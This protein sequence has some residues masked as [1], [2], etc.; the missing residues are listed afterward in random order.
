MFLTVIGTFFNILLFLLIMTLVVS[1]HELGH[2]LFA[3]RAK[4]LCHE[5][6]IGF[7][8]VLF[9]R[10]RGETRFSVRSI[11]IGGYVSMAGE[12]IES[13]L[14][15]I[16]MTIRVGFDQKG[17]VNRIV[18]NPE[19][20]Q[21]HDFQ[22][23]KI[24]KYDLQGKD[25]KDLYINDYK[26]NRDAIYVFDKKQLQIAPYNR[27]YS[28][29]SKSQR[30]MTTF[31]GPLMNLILALVLYL[32]ISFIIGVPNT[33]S[34]V[35]GGVVDESPASGIIL[36]GDEIT[37]INGVSIDA[38]SSDDATVTSLGSELDKY[39]DNATFT[40]TVLRDGTEMTLDAI[41]PQYYFFGLGFVS[42][43]TQPGL[44]I[45]GPLYRNSLLLPG[46]VIQAING[47][48]FT[49]WKDVILYQLSHPEG[50]TEDSP[51]S[52][53]ILRGEETFTFEYVAL[54][55]DT[56]DAMGYDLFDSRIGISGTNHFSFFGCIENGFVA[57]GNASISIYKTLALVV[58]NNGQIG[59]SDLSG[60][61][62]IYSM[63]ATAASQGILSLL[64]WVA[65]LS[66]NLGIINL[67]PL[68]AL[69][70]GRLAFLGY[71]AITRKR[72]NPKVENMIH[73]IGFILLMGLMVFVFYNDILRA[74]GL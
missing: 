65:L 62:G 43:P 22:E 30:F 6:A 46:D 7:G 1:I 29:K 4:I 14:L 12:E 41:T 36:P 11:P 8:P 71:E 70:G 27:N 68:P 54:S 60:F 55:A 73:F 63:T 32:L 59:V 67:L 47:F 34:T 16:G 23:V 2:L 74:F 40:V 72:P 50:S 5:Y 21:F 49:N 28:N 57:L 31:G 44:M 15:K 66:V 20:V 48:T 52:I 37:A 61:L 19:N 69:D 39:L 18:I 64:S 35:V 45:A 25:G 26:V 10:K 17:L 42:D 33:A 56:L 9:S 24:E 38:W 53:T 13:D 58:Q 3:K 51:T